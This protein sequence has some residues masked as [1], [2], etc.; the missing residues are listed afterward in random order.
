MGPNGSLSGAVAAK[1]LAPVIER[2]RLGVDG[3]VSVTAD[4]AYRSGD[5]EGPR[6]AR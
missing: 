4:I 3:V 5:A 1:S 6:G 2:L